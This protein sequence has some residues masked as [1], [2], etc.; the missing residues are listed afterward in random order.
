MT[1]VLLDAEHADEPDQR[2][3]VGEDADDVGAAADLAVEAFERVGRP[4]LAP[5]VGGKAVEGEDVGL[6]VFE[7]GGHLA[8]RPFQVG[9]GFGEPVARLGRRVGVEDRPDQRGQQPVLVL[10]R[11]AETV[12]EEVHRAALPGATE[13]LGDRR[14][15]PGVS[16]RD[17]ELHPDQPARDQAPEEVGPEHLGLGLADIDREDLAA[18]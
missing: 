16:I 10:A 12:P 2:A 9:D 1:F 17:R 3:V 13:H 15:E 4:E 7:Q 5:V 6:G 14:L 8:E 11:V 18:A